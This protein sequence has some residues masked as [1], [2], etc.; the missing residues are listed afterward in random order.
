MLL[1]GIRVLFNFDILD[2]YSE[3]TSQYSSFIILCY[4]RILCYV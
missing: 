4:V 3:I 1:F 2:F